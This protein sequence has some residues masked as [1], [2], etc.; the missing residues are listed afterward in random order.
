[1][2]RKPP[3]RMAEALERENSSDGL[4][5]AERAVRVAEMIAEAVERGEHGPNRCVCQ[6]CGQWVSAYYHHELDGSW[7]C[8]E[9]WRKQQPES[10]ARD[11]RGVVRP[12][13]Q[14][15]LAAS[16]MMKPELVTPRV[17]PVDTILAEETAGE[18]PN[19]GADELFGV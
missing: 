5:V 1:M 17:Q 2:A 11:T 18:S 3:D 8:Y 12:V 14:P 13:A 9:C 7:I 4:T 10:S 19:R 6:R 15:V 16:K